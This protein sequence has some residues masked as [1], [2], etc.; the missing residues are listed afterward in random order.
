MTLLGTAAEVP[1]RRN[2]VLISLPTTEIEGRQPADFPPTF[3]NQAGDSQTPISIARSL[4]AAGGS[5][6]GMDGTDTEKCGKCKA[7]K[8]HN[9]PSEVS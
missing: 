5:D 7:V 3:R 2:F 4:T 6:V 8:S 9:D 1:P